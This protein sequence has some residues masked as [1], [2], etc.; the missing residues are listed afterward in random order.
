M[1]RVSHTRLTHVLEQMQQRFGVVL[2]VYVMVEK[3]TKPDHWLGCHAQHTVRSVLFLLLD[4]LGMGLA[5]IPHATANNHNTLHGVEE[6]A[7]VLS[8]LRYQNLH[9]LLVL[10]A[11]HANHLLNRDGLGVEA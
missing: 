6:R 9:P 4:E 3:L 2:I 10:N 1:L 8:A 11:A 5:F 7:E